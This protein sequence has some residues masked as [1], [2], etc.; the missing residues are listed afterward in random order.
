MSKIVFFSFSWKCINYKCYKFMFIQEPKHKTIVIQK[1]RPFYRKY[2]S[3]I[4]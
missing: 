1:L 4:I 3:N 2:N